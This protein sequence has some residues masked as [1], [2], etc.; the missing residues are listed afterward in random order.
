VVMDEPIGVGE[1][2]R[3][4]RLAA[5]L[6]QEELAEHAGISV[7]G[8]SDV[9]RGL[10][11]APRSET[12]RRLADALG[13]LP[14][15]RTA[16]LST[17]GRAYVAV[18]P[19]T[20]NASAARLPNRSA[21]QVGSAKLPLPLTSFVG[22]ERELAALAEVLARSRMLTLVGTGGVGKTRVALR[23][24]TS[25]VPE[26]ADA[27]YVVELAPIVEAAHVPDAVARAMGILE[28]QGRPPHEALAVSLASRR[29]L[30]VL[31]NCEHL[32]EACARLAISLLTCCAGLRVLA[33]SREPL[34]VPGEVVSR[35]LP[36]A[37]FPHM[38]DG[39]VS[40]AVQLFVE[41]AQA[42]QPGFALTPS[43]R[44]VVA[45][46]CGRL[47]GLPLAIELA[48]ACARMLSPMEI[49]ARL[50][51][52]FRLL[53]RGARAAPARQR[54][55]AAT[56]D[57]SY[58]LLD[59]AE[60]HLFDCLSVFAGGFSLSAAEAVCGDT[61]DAGSAPWTVL[62]QLSGLV[63]RSLVDVDPP[64]EDG[65]TH[66]RLLET[67]RAYAAERLHVR[68]EHELL[69]R[70]HARWLVSWAEEADRAGHGRDEVRWLRRV[71]RERANVRA[72]LQWAVECGDAAV[73]LRIANALGWYTGLLGTPS[74]SLAALEQ[75]LALAGSSGL[76]ALRA[77]ALVETGR[78][79]LFRSEFD[80]A[81]AALE[82]AETIGCEIG[83]TA[84]VL[85][86]RSIT[87][88]LLQFTGRHD[89]AVR[90]AGDLLAEARDLADVWQ[91]GRALAVLARGA[92]MR[93]DVGAAK[94]HL[95]ESAELARA[96]GDV[97]S[98]AMAL[99]DLGDVAR[100]SGAPAEAAALYGES[101]LLRRRFGLRGPALASVIHNLG[102]LALLGDDIQA[103]A[104][105]FT[106]ALDEFSLLGERR[107]MAECLIG[108]AGVQ[109]A[110]GQARDAAC[111]FAAADTAFATLGSGPWPSHRQAQERAIARARSVLGAEAFNR[112]W[113]QGRHMTLDKA[114]TM[115]RERLAGIGNIAL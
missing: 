29:V 42:A 6:T 46:L 32:A 47:D 18:Q 57:W 50:D 52:R 91:Q 45:D 93:G 71:A 65:E 99:A 113:R 9:E 3:Q 100:E 8:L 86:A 108:L 103:A 1:L 107:G 110:S 92:L 85:M 37:L 14:V 95:Q 19:H 80:T 13:L 41:R 40:E 24:A 39:S 4:Y 104:A 28:Q 81:R 76:T 7:R 38:S 30:L 72:A 60:Q 64:D 20:G 5:G 109:L 25:A 33:T 84:T 74:E 111:L 51:H 94:V 79:A 87:M 22:R 56:L 88:A 15:D 114:V 10:H 83:D 58:D 89:E 78:L 106:E 105:H 54:T 2:L 69:R 48:A 23:L 75:A 73:A 90:R 21:A 43:N 17:R 96:Q 35:V 115:A 101:L 27:V 112:A 16:L 26:L 36:L 82:T 77:R 31:D 63:E 98:L 68:G 11:R 66:Y 44:T 102:D 67:L 53:T 49:A 34:G 59:A 97:W 55:L 12:L 62:D 70:R 61:P